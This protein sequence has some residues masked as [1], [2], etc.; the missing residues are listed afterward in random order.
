MVCVG[1]ED[2][3]SCRFVVTN[4]LGGIVIVCMEGWPEGRI[5]VSSTPANARKASA[6]F[7]VV[8]RMLKKT[9]YCMH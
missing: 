7:I 4:S 9:M 2:G 6:S 1:R 3:L 5:E 8:K